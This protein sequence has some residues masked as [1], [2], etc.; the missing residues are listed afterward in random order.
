M[1]LTRGQVG[2]GGVRQ[3]VL[4]G[5]KDE[6]LS[7]HIT[8]SVTIPGQYKGSE[9]QTQCVNQRSKRMRLWGGKV[10]LIEV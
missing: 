3:R 1:Q 9:K 8:I 5:L 6:N 10:T 7:S 2:G 4:E